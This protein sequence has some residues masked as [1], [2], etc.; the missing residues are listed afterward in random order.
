MAFCQNCGAQMSGA[1]CTACGT[2]AKGA[3]VPAA[4]T[5][6]G[7]EASAMQPR[8][9]SPLVWVLVAILGLFI[10]IGIG[11]IGAGVFVMHKAK[12]AGL[13]PDL[14]RHNPGLAVGKLL[15]ATNPDLEVISVD[16]G[17]EN[18]Q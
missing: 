12:Q 11:V 13:D 15:A 10:L 3:A 8:K 17:Q 1:F 7:M 4:P 16:D 14:M 6:P 5:A 2:Q 18:P 9:T